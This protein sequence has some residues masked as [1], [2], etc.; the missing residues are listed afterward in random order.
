MWTV[1]LL[2]LAGC[3]GGDADAAS[4]EDPRFAELRTW[5]AEQMRTWM[6]P[7]AAIVV[8]ADGE[9]HVA[10]L[11]VRR[12]GLP[13]PVTPDT[14]FRVGSVSKMVAGALVAEE[15]AAGRLDLDAPASDVLGD[16]S[17]GDA[18]TFADFSLLQLS[19]HSAGLQTIGLPRTCDFDPSALSEVLGELT[20]EWVLWTPP[21][22]L[23]NY[24]NQHYSLLGLAAERSGGAPYSEL[25]QGLFDGAGMAS[26]TYDWLDATAADHAT[27]HTMDLATGDLEEYRGFEERAC[28]ASFPSG[29][30]MA[31]ANDVGQ[32]LEVLLSGGEGWVTPE[33]WEIMTTQGWNRSET[34]GYGFGLASSSYRG[35]PTLGHTGT[36]GGFLAMVWAVPGE[37]LGVGVLVNVS[38]LVTDPPEPWSKPTQRIVQ[39]A[40]DLFL[41]L[42][43]EERVSTVRPVEEWGRY[44]GS[45]HSD[46][47]LGDVTIT[48]DGD[49]LW[50][51]DAARTTALLPL[52]RDSFLYA[53]PDDDG[54]ND[55]VGVSFE[56]GSAEEITWLLTDVG[57]GRKL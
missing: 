27:G 24:S 53:I 6:I 48:L 12:W 10:G 11:G 28:V 22:E 52:G 4:D 47:E 31:S 46:Y 44:V 42:E 35:F 3:R 57:V 54:T 32:L 1:V 17:L 55:Y 41:G 37:Q 21:G 40:L 38:H 14:L 34:G 30:L 56:E 18:H 5:A 9:V 26:A 43:P 39:H 36:V 23:Y 7:G 15:A 25:A 19:G 50:Y 45:Y 16:L 2:L 13:D 29:G 49:T 20:P 33:A 8:V 51:A